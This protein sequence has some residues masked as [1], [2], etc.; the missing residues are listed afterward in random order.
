[1][2]DAAMKLL[3]DIQAAAV[4]PSHSLSDLLRRCQILAFRLRHEPF[5]AWVANE[6]NGYSA[7]DVLP[8]YRADLRGEIEADLSGPFGSSATDVP[9]PVTLMPK[10]ARHDA[11]HLDFTHGV[12]ALESLVT[13][14]RA[15]KQSTVRS[16][17]PVEVFAQLAVLQGYATMQM[18]VE[19]PISSVVGVLDQVRSRALTF[20]LEIEAENPAA[21][22]TVV[23][24]D[25]PVA[26]RA[27]PS[28]PAAPPPGRGGATR[29][30]D[31]N[32]GS[33][34]AA[35]PPR[36]GAATDR[37]AELSQFTLA[38]K[39][40][41]QEVEVIYARWE[42][43]DAATWS[44]EYLFDLPGIRPKFADVMTRWFDLTERLGPVLDL[45]LGPRYR[46]DTY[47]DN[48]FL[49]AVTAAEGYH[50]I[51]CSNAVL[52]RATHRGIV[53]A[54]L[55]GVPDE[56]RTCLREGLGHS[57]EPTLRERLMGLHGRVAGAITG[58]V[59]RAE[60][61]AGPVV[62]ERNRSTHRDAARQDGSAGGATILKL[63]HQV[64]LVLTA[65]LLLDL[66]FDLDRA[67][68][69][70]RR[71]RRFSLLRDVLRDAN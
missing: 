32:R 65:C 54:A 39:E 27:S 16:P 34:D 23:T 29:R 10:D 60:E 24:G 37:A 36:P 8:P 18:W 44:F 46:P 70:I 38:G 31:A 22:E 9:V 15:A 30:R 47:V 2:Q 7:S 19:V 12:A 42:P 53:K 33:A 17:F 25:P 20:V 6:L 49:N 1:M 63:S 43:A 68:D 52:P 11:T 50:R 4:D 66:G 55:E 56:H 62:R 61:F 67:G 57:S 14:T 3:S 35:A 58:I 59:G 41:G 13:D 28:P 51:T 45:I 69:M 26:G 5:K 21:G 64:T 71:T 48:H 40:P